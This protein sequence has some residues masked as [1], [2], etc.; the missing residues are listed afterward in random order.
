MTI[1]GSLSSPLSI[2]FSPLFLLRSA[3][4]RHR[5]DCYVTICTIACAFAQAWFIFGS[6]TTGSKPKLSIDILAIVQKFLGMYL[7]APWTDEA[8]TQ[9]TLGFSLL[10]LLALWAFIMRKR[11]HWVHLVL[12]YCFLMSIL[13]AIQ[14]VDIGLIHP[15]L[16]GQRYF[17]YPHSFLGWFI[18][19]LLAISPRKLYPLVLAALL[20]ISLKWRWIDSRHHDPENWQHHLN[21]CAD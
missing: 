3:L 9:L 11:L 18:V 15:T 7:Y 1:I 12:S 5:N 16:S 14:R 17:F 21:A 19:Q 20:A 6:E 2:V 4:T 10:G 13:I 8:K